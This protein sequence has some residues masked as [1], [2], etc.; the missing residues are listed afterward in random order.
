MQLYTTVLMLFHLSKWTEGASKMGTQYHRRRNPNLVCFDIMAYCN[1][2]V[3]GEGHS[4]PFYTFIS[5]VAAS[6]L[7]R[8]LVP[9]VFFLLYLLH[10][11]LLEQF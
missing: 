10:F 11:L 8:S 5:A 4:I 1:Q 7:F 2:G 9:T 3:D 6:F